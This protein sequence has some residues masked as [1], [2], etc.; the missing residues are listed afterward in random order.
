MFYYFISFLT[1]WLS[2]TKT[3]SAVRLIEIIKHDWLS[4]FPYGLIVKKF[5]PIKLAI[6]NTNQSTNWF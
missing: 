4:I 5:P 1:N 2:D 3:I 6:V